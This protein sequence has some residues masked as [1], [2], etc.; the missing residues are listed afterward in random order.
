VEEAEINCAEYKESL[1]LA[2]MKKTVK[3]AE[4]TELKKL[5]QKALS[6]VNAPNTKL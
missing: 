2:K 6:H 4:K 5:H 3:K 1:A